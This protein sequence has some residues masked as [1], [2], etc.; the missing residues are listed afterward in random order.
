VLTPKH[1]TELFCDLVDLKVTDKVIDPCCGTAGFLIAAM[2]DMLHKTDDEGQQNNI[3][4]NQLHG[5]ELQPYMFTIATTN[6]ILR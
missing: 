6:M 5:I 3:K 2:R 4:K 1:I